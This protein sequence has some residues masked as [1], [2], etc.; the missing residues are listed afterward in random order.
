[1][2][3]LLAKLKT[4]Q[5]VVVLAGEAADAAM[6]LYKKPNVSKAREFA[7][8][9]HVLGA[10]EWYYV[11]LTTDEQERMLGG[12]ESESTLGLDP[13]SKDNCAQIKTLYFSAGSEKIFSKVGKKQVAA[14][15]KRV[16]LGG[17]GPELAQDAASVTLGGEVHAYWNGARLFFK[18]FSQIQPLF[19]GIAELYRQATQK[20]TNQFLSSELFELRSEMSDA[21]VGN[22]NRRLIMNMLAAKGNELSDPAMLEKYVDYAKEYNLDLE[23][24][25]GKIA[26]VDNGDISTVLGLLDERYYTSA[27]TGER[28][29]TKSSKK[30]VQGKRKHAR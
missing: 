10:D 21:V 27:V 15:E 9:G 14:G 17:S 29:E 12:Y 16:V 24:E 7:V 30:L 11:V 28:R 5:N 13:L 4:G 1:M 6:Q 8:D 2:S 26:L 23:I 20:E 18:K 3:T 19:P 25:N 22:K